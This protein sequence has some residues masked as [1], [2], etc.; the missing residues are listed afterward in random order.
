MTNTTDNELRSHDDRR[1]FRL[2]TIIKGITEGRRRHHRRIDE[3]PDAQ[4]DWY[5]P[6]LFKFVIGIMLMSILDAMF[7]LKLIANGAVEANPVMDYFLSISVPAFVTAK[8]ILTCF[9]IVL[10]T[11]LSSYLFLNR[12]LISRFIVISFIG[13]FVL[14][15]Y[16]LIL[17][18]V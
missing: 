11:A 7:T 4:R 2:S 9:A 3:N 10:M 5:H 16:E 18:S 15:S 1:E 14:I 13:Y 8:M 6:R 17:L 12:F